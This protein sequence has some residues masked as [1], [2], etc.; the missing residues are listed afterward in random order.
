[1]IADDESEMT[2]ARRSIGDGLMSDRRH[3]E[4]SPAV[5][6]GAAELIRRNLVKHAR[7]YSSE[8]C[9]IRVWWSYHP[10]SHAQTAPLFTFPRRKATRC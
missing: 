2:A 8:G 10:I 5:K 7:G 3:Q 6:N 1:M 9:G 4:R